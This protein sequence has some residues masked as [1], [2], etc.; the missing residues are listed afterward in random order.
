[1]GS[2]TPAL[3]PI[4]G[5]HRLRLA[6][7]FRRVDSAGESAGESATKGTTIFMARA[8]KY[9]YIDAATQIENLG[10][11]I[12]LR[13]LLRLLE[14]R[15]TVTVDVRNVP[16][17]AAEVIEI[18]P[19]IAHTSGSFTRKMLAAGLRRRLGRTSEQGY[20]VL[21]PGHIG[22][23]YDVK[24]SLGRIG[25]VA[26]TG[27]CR[28]L[29]VGIVR[30]CFSVDDLKSPLLQIERVQARLQTVYAPRDRVSERYARAVGVR[31]TGRSTDLAYTLGVRGGTT[32]RSG[33]VL[34]FAASTDGHPQ[35][36]YADRLAAFLKDYLAFLAP[37]GTAVRYCAQVVRDAQFGDRVLA[38]HPQVPR[39]AF[40]RTK[41]TADA[42]F[43]TYSGA[44]T[45]LTNRLHSFL[46]ALSQGA[47]AI[48]VTDPA[49]HGK[50]VGIIQEMGL[51]ELLVSLDGLTPQVLADHVD[52]VNRDRARIIGTVRAF[53]DA[54]TRRLESLLDDLLAAPAVTDS[55]VA[56]DAR[57]A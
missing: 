44:E 39:V 25:L 48:V 37:T 19:D 17:W 2:P 35:E 46:F 27:L 11:D 56:T 10:D 13:Q 24:Q 49:R 9:T 53:F 51:P 15:S 38:G 41:Q 22:G 55:M 26:L 4:C 21:K 34:S 14:Q 42:V 3:T 7:G 32:D 52:A 57:A 1:M 28:L 23:R 43:Q 54:Q 8:A 31:T 45:V 30:L 12:I 29:G 16:A 6:G 40:E 5:E 18:D 20:L 33:V 47:V 36:D 50:I